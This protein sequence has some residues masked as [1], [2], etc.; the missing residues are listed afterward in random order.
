MDA[1]CEPLPLTQTQVKQA[2]QNSIGTRLPDASKELEGIDLNNVS[3]ESVFLYKLES[4]VE[5]RQVN[6]KIELYD[7]SPIDG[8]ENGPIPD[9]WDA[10]VIPP[11]NF[12]EGEVTYLI[13][14]SEE[15]S[16]CASCDGE[17]KVYCHKCNG[18]GRRVPVQL[19]TNQKSVKAGKP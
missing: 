17:G 16:V 18:Y 1:I 5:M 3:T 4:L 2:L 14:H 8:R 12:M 7:G 6:K 13:P 15:V 9:V 19:V 11:G 10:P